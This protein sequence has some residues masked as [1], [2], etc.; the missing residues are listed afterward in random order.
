MSASSPRRSHGATTDRPHLTE[1]RPSS[2]TAPSMP[3]VLLNDRSP[4]IQSTSL[5]SRRS[6]RSGHRPHLRHRTA[7]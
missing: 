2:M 1:L 5:S 3:S 6:A 4:A 7:R